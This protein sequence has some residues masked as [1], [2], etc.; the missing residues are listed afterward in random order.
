L[1]QQ[2]CGIFSHSAYLGSDMKKEEQKFLSVMKGLMRPLVRVLIAHGISAPA[3]Y[4]LMKAVYVDVA[5]KDFRIGSEPPTDSRITL[6]TGVHRRDVRAILS[7]DTDSWETR[8]SKTAMFATVLGQWLSRRGYQDAGGAPLP[9]ARKAEN[10]P[11]FEALVSDIN[12]DIRPRT[13]LDELVRQELVVET[14]D[15]LLTVSDKARKGP[16]SDEDR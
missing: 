13:V 11:S 5:H 10:G 14:E 2:I 4:K 9:L 15:G 16:V 6:L 1:G 8:R 7:D 12:R 3:F